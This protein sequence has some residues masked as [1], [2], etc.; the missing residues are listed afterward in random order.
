M[1]KIVLNPTI[2]FCDNSLRELLNFRGD[3]I[4][5][6]V[7]Q[8]FDVV[9]VAPA[10]SILGDLKD[11]VKFY[12]TNVSRSSMN[13]FKDIVYMYRLFTI[14]KKERPDIIFHYTIKPNIYGS[15]VSKMLNIKSVAV[16]TGLGYAFNHSSFK[17]FVA[18]LLYKFA[19]RFPEYVFVLNCESATMLVSHKIVKRNNI[20]CLEGGEGI[21]LMKYKI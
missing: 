18:R 15:I 21:N 1:K 14:Y 6:F 12:E 5:H 19:L 7:M 8:D 4:K 9:L 2:V 10:N 3:V 13:P 20:I 11:K 16:V 17:G